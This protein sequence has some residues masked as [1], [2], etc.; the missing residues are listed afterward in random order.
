MSQMLE[1]VKVSVK[2]RAFEDKLAQKSN[3]FLR[4][5]DMLKMLKL[6]QMPYR[7]MVRTWEMFKVLKTLR[8]L[9]EVGGGGL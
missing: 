6:L 3:N 1:C 7:H 9:G 4:T 5:K 2:R 8:V